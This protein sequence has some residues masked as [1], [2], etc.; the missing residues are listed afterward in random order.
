M[1]RIN[2]IS[3]NTFNKSSGGATILLVLVICVGIAVLSQFSFHNSRSMQSLQQSSAAQFYA[4][5]VTWTGVEAF[6]KY[7]EDLDETAVDNLPSELELTMDELNTQMLVSNIK[8]TATPLEGS[9]RLVTA[10]FQIV[11]NNR[12]ATSQIEA[13]FV[14]TFPPPPITA[15]LG[16]A[17]SGIR[18]NT[19]PPNTMYFV[20]NL[21][22]TGN[23]IMKHAA[24]SAG[25]LEVTGNVHIST[26]TFDGISEIIANGDVELESFNTFDL[27]HADGD[28]RLAQGAVVQQVISQGDVFTTENGQ[29]VNIQADGDIVLN[30]NNT[31]FASAGGSIS[32]G[33]TPSALGGGAWNEHGY[34]ESVGGVFLYDKMLS[35]DEIYTLGDVT[36]GGAYLRDVTTI[37]AGG[38]LDCSIAQYAT[39]TNVNVLGSAVNC[40][41]GITG[42]GAASTPTPTTT[43]ASYL[44]PPPQSLINLDSL[45]AGIQVAAFD[46]ATYRDEAN[47]IITPTIQNNQLK[48][49]EVKVKDVAGINDGIYVIGSTAA[50]P[51]NIPNALCETVNAQ[52]LCSN[53]GPHP[54]FC[55]GPGWYETG[56]HQLN[57]CFEYAVN[58]QMFGIR[59]RYILPGIVFVEGDLKLGFNN[60]DGLSLRNTILVTGN[61]LSANNA[62][63]QA[64]N[65]STKDEICHLSFVD[66]NNPFGNNYPI[67]LCDPK[68]EDVVYTALSNLAVGAGTFDQATG[69][70]SGGDITLNSRGAYKGSI[71][72]GNRLAYDHDIEVFGSVVG[73]SQRSAAVTHTISGNGRVIFDEG[74]GVYDPTDLPLII[75]GSVAS[76]VVEEGVNNTDRVPLKNQ[77]KLLWSRYK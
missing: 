69:K 63:V 28:V 56:T 44:T 65:F 55:Y 50:S 12:I 11:A 36:L 26:S 33:A 29:G 23:Q 38:N 39:L 51:Y 71:L 2:A 24:G 42:A 61:Y 21:E 75:S 8:Q 6:R 27:V 31:A 74:E 48:R 14:L 35:T 30:G 9:D 54:I 70:Y 41:A 46:V 67:Q 57:T 5:S 49:V 53:P 10:N 32:S 47:Y 13:Q 18:A 19:I 66:S 17:A 7:L 59:A 64:V 76:E 3:T 68:L 40:P 20:G 34:L 58:E 45:S 22:M 1:S 15:G 43:T 25:R 62:S 77:S 52:G 4:K 16:S 72:A 60:R 37:N 73:L